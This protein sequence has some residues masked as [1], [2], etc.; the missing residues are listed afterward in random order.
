M[1]VAKVVKI[2]YSVF[3]TLV[4][5]L[6]SLNIVNLIGRVGK[7]PEVKYLDSG[8]VV[9]NLTLAVNRLSRNAEEPDWF[10]LELWDKT[11]EVAANYVKKG[12]QIG[13]TGVLKFDHW[14]DRNTGT[15]RSRPVVRV[16]RLELLGSKRDAEA[17]ASSGP[18]YGG[19]DE[20]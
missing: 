5:K 9:C 13:V 6:M 17:A 20:F 3:S 10:S 7:D 16:D 4:P 8:K 12:T 14:T 18:S 2:G 11:A 19:D 1:G 15:E